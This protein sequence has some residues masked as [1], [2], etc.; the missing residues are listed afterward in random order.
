MKPSRFL[1]RQ[2]QNHLLRL[3]VFFL[4]ALAASCSP[5][6]PKEASRSPATV[7]FDRSLYASADELLI[8]VED[9]DENRN[10]ASVETVQVSLSVRNREP[11]RTVKLIE[12]GANTGVFQ[13]K[14]AVPLTSRPP[15]TKK[16]ALYAEGGDVIK[17]TYRDRDDPTDRREQQAR[18]AG[19]RFT[20]KIDPSLRPTQ[21]YV[22]GETDRP[23]GAVINPDGIRDQFVVNEIIVSA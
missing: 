3:S 13:S 14:E 19:G 5:I 6:P 7:S 1:A 2:H 17:V 18:V 20:Y 15:K 12:T 23:L 4:A 9:A 22:G 21:D 10:P 11:T 16:P 8:T